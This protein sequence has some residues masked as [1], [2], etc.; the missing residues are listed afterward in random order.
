MVVRFEVDACVPSVS[1]SKPAQAASSTMDDLVGAFSG[2]NLIPNTESPS[3]STAGGSAGLQFSA[4]AH[5]F[6]SQQSS[7]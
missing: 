3:K 4:A 1:T 6:L 5:L 2:I 7:S